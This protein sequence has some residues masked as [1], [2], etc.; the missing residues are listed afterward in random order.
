MDLPSDIGGMLY[1]NSEWELRI[2]RAMQRIDAGS[3][4][5]RLG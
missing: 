5:D 3:D 1:A 2:A 4:L